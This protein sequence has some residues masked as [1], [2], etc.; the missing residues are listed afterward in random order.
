MS[1]DEATPRVA[2]ELAVPEFAVPELS[3]IVCSYNGARTLEACLDALDRQNVRSMIEVI[4]VDDGSSDRTSEIAERSGVCAISFEQNRGL[5]AARNAGLERA[6]APLVAFTDDDCVPDPAWAQRIIEAFADDAQTLGVG[7]EVDALHHDSVVRR[8]LAANNPLQ[9]LEIEFAKGAGLINRLRI[10]LRQTRG[11]RGVRREVFSL[12]GASMAFRRSA[13]NAVGGFEPDIQ[14]GGDD[15][16]VCTRIREQFGLGTLVVDSR[17]RVAHDFEP[18]LRDTLRRSFAYGVGNG[19]EWTWHGGLPSVGP[20]PLASAVAAIVLAPVG[21]GAAVCATV[22]VPVV[23][24]RRW[25]W[26][27]ARQ[28]SGEPLLWPLLQFSQE[29]AADVGF[30]RGWWLHRGVRP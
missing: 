30:V 27:A 4:V 7:G 3:V 13:L 5:S 19:R 25:I 1:L 23:V 15:E 26:S 8:Y 17:V 2:A 10:Y 28:R 29:V 21:V 18:K 20:T 11:H 14:F 24:Y 22:A 12:V 9:P 16:Y 6:V